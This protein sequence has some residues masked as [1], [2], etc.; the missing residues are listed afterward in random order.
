[1]AVE[2]STYMLWSRLFQVVS[3]LIILSSNGFLINLSEF[4][5]SPPSL[6]KGETME[7]RVL[8]IGWIEALVVTSKG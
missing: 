7:L 1:M 2:I 8:C 6:R 4:M 5:S 3:C